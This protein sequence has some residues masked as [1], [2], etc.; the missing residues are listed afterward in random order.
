ML[1]F[2][3]GFGGIIIGCLLVWFVVLPVLHWFTEFRG[4]CGQNFF[5]FYIAFI[6]GGKW[7]RFYK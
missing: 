5:G 2:G 3:G 7:G 4:N 6:S 1:E